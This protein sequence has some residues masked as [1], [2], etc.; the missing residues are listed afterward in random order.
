MQL[1][2]LDLGLLTP[3]PLH[4]RV[5]PGEELSY[6]TVQVAL[7]W[8]FSQALKKGQIL[9][10]GTGAALRGQEKGCPRQGGVSQRGQQCHGVGGQA[11]SPAATAKLSPEQP[12]D[13]PQASDPAGSG[14]SG[15]KVVARSLVR[16][17]GSGLSLVQNPVHYSLAV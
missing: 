6:P 11:G 12:Q 2:W 14:L 8:H 1:I 5:C 13:G 16:S 9:T 15:Q 7:V 17:N 10:H 4:P 3:D